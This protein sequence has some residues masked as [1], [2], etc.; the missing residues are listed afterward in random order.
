MTPV[1]QG[2]HDQCRREDVGAGPAQF[3]GHWQALDSEL[4]T[5]PPRLPRK[6]PCILELGKVLVEL[7]PGK[8]GGGV[9]QLTLLGTK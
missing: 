8:V 7:P 5:L 4:G 9:G 6:V 3:R 1:S 2:F